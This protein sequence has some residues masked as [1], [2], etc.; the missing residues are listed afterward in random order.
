MQKLI[1][2]IMALFIAIPAFGAELKTEDQKALYSLGVILGREVQGFNL[3]PEETKFVQQG[4][5]DAASGKPLDVQPEAYQQRIKEIA[6]SKIKA[7]AEKQKIASASFL[8]KAAKEKGARKTASG[9]IFI[10]V[11]DG[12]GKQPSSTSTVKVHYTGRL[13]DGTVFD[14]SVQRGKPVEFP[15]NKVIP[16]WTEGLTMMKVGGKAKLVCPS[17]IAYGDLG[18]PPIIPGGATLVFKVELLGIKK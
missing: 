2:F 8:E 10:P 1:V 9:L 6:Q 3:S 5:A 17:S 16:C 11:K 18:R 13:I 12:K 15:L 7:S 4:F 14:S